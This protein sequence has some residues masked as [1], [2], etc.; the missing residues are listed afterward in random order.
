MWKWKQPRSGFWTRVSISYDNIYC[1]AR[2]YGNET[3]ILFW[4]LYHPFHLQSS[5]DGFLRQTVFSFTPGKYVSIFALSHQLTLATTPRSTAIKVE[6]AKRIEIRWSHRSLYFQTNTV[7]DHKYLDRSPE[8]PHSYGIQVM[9]ELRYS[10]T[11]DLCKFSLGFLVL[12]HINLHGLF[13]AK[14][15]L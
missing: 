2:M 14:L 10:S 13:S 7:W 8:K 4:T 12:W 3:N 1:T 6:E 5:Q 9:V 15:F 11:Y